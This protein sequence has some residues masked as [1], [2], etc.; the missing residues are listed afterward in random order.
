MVEKNLP[1]R[2]LL[3]EDDR[4]MAAAVATLLLVAGYEVE[5]AFD[6]ETALETAHSFEPQLCLVDLDVP[7]LNIY[8]FARSLRDL[9]ENPPFLANVTP[10]VDRDEWDSDAEFD[11]DF[12]RPSDPLHVAKQVIDFLRSDLPKLSSAVTQ[13]GRHNTRHTRQTYRRS[14]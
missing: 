10:F 8:D 6:G 4:E 1:R 9:M 5:M 14:I 11:L 2:V 7:R 3:V 12:S 13:P